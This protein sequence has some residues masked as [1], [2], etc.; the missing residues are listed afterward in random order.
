VKPNKN[1]WI[2]KVLTLF[3]EMF[4]GI[5][6]HSLAGKALSAG[7]WDLVPVNIRDFAPNN[8]GRVDD[9][10]FGGGSGMVMRADVLDSAIKYS[11]LSGAPI[12]YFTPR[13]ERLSQDLVGVFAN[14]P[15]VTLICG[16]YEGV[17]QRALDANNVIEIS[18]GDFILSGGEPAALS[19]IDAC[20]RLLPGVIGDRSS[21][22]EESFNSGLLEYPLFTRPAD[23]CGNKVPEVL[24][25][26]NHKNISAWKNEQSKIA[27]R[28]RRPDLWDRY[29]KNMK[30]QKEVCYER[31]R[32]N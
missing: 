11:A 29:K 5:L 17:D 19:L 12:V 4:P 21:L 10:P 8:D 7:I 2:A 30:N 22:E 14:G 20:V 31:D 15:G 25:S 24:I 6:S 32:R 13:G 27:T 1:K 28:T 16:R 9:I 26:G 23:W 18:L 3:P